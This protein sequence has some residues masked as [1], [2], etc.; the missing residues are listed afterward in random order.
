MPRVVYVNGRYLPYA[1]ALIHIDD[2]G[3]TFADGVYEVIGVANCRLIDEAPHLDR[4]ERSLRELRIAAPMSRRAVQ[5]VV[6]ELIR[7]NRVTS[8]LVYLQMSRGVAPRD[9]AFPRDPQTQFVGWAKNVYAGPSAEDGIRVVTTPDLRWARCDIKSTSLLPN[10]LAKQSARDA[11]A[12]EAWLVDKD[13]RVTEG[14]STNSWIVTRDGE[15]I[16]HAL[17][18]MILAGVTRTTVAALARTE[19]LKLVERPFSVAE[20]KGAREAFLTSTTLHVLPVVQI[21]DQVIGNGKPGS[22]TL[23]LRDAYLRYLG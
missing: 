21:D 15:L 5:L 3:Y 9:H 6:R 2:R 18:T 13:G 20:A 10:V 17:D 16:T 11:G 7:R 12:Y 14:S 8:G 23:R 19:R 4:L 1:A 22:L